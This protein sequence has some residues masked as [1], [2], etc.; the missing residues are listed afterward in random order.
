MHTQSNGIPHG[1]E[2]NQNKRFRI[3]KGMEP[4]KRRRPGTLNSSRLKV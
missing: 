2:D 4:I 1:I 3:W